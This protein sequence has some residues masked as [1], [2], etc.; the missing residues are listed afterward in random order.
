MRRIRA[1]SIIVVLMMSLVLPAETQVQANEANRLRVGLAAD[2]VGRQELRADTY[3][4]RPALG[5]DLGWRLDSLTFGASFRRTEDES[6]EGA[7]SARVVENQFSLW[8]RRGWTID[9]NWALWGELG[10]GLRQAQMSAQIQEDSISE[11]SDP[12]LVNSLALGLTY[13]FWRTWQ[14]DLRFQALK[15][16]TRLSLETSA[17]GAILKTF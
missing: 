13:D 14:F 10:A 8:V 7:Q 6:R 1:G 3:A 4:W 15:A 5:L 16:Q 11:S 9:L 2:W 12:E 17:G